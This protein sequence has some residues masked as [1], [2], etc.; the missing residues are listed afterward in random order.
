M[1][2]GIFVAVAS[3]ASVALATVTSKLVPS[4]REI[5]FEQRSLWSDA[6]VPQS[7][8]VLNYA[9]AS[10]HPPSAAIALYAHDESPIL[11]VEDFDRVLQSVS[12]SSAIYTEL[13]DVILVEFLDD[14]AFQIAETE[15]TALQSFFVVTSHAGCNLED[16]H[17]AWR[18]ITAI[19]DGRSLSLTLVVEPVRM[20]DIVKSFSVKY[21]HGGAQTWAPRDALDLT[22]RDEHGFDDT[23]NFGFNPSI[24]PRLALFPPNISLHSWT[25]ACWRPTVGRYPDERV[26]GTQLEGHPETS[27]RPSLRPLKRPPSSWFPAGRLGGFCSIGPLHSTWLLPPADTQVVPLLEAGRRLR[28]PVSSRRL[29]GGVDASVAEAV[30]SQ[31]T[32]AQV[33]LTCVDCAFT[34]NV[35]IGLDFQVDI[36]NSSCLTSDAACFTFGNA[37]MNMTIEQ[38]EQNAALEMF[39]AKELQAGAN[40]KI[41]EV[42]VAP[43]LI[44]PSLIDLGPAVGLEIAFELDL[45]SSINF[46]FGA[47]AHVPSGAFASVSLVNATGDWDPT[48]TATGWDGSSVDQ[49]PFRV[50]G[51]EFN[52]STSMALAAFAEISF[53]ILD[54]GAALRLVQN[55]PKVGMDAALQTGVNRECKPIGADDFES[56]GTAFVVGSGLTLSTEAELV[57]EKGEFVGHSIPDNW[58]LTLWAKDVPFTPALG[59]NT[60]ACFVL[61]DDGASV[62][63]TVTSGKADLDVALAGVPAPTGTLFPA[64]SAVPTWDFNKIESY[65][66]ANGQLPTNVNYAQMVQATTVPADLQAAVTKA[67]KTNSAA[68][69][70]SPYGA[71]WLALRVLPVAALFAG[72]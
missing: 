68:V 65:Y 18:V 58:D 26:A 39:I 23:F 63:L 52:I 67:A 28:Q 49:V 16:E 5:A 7:V 2:A 37:A 41:I 8:A 53:T 14:Q 12:C 33:A 70:P 15:W 25:S 24:D 40:Y 32:D 19:P 51:G 3:F 11:L 60:T 34:T 42:P 20:R 38:F 66:S 13:G 54:V 21:S 29:S 27:P 22:R 48:F 1:R 62:N 30:I 50:N 55:M 71:V 31:L 61:A 4:K 46:T 69:R 36:A 6:I 59:I 57:L 44:V 47:T 10:H 9:T 64:Q 72:L 45:A 43:A 56:F 17:G 35:T